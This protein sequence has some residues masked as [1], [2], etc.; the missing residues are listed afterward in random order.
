[1]R[2]KRERKWLLERWERKAMRRK[3]E[4]ENEGG[5]VRSRQ[6]HQRKRKGKEHT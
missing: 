6:P 2:H 5:W 3:Q 4:S 1:M